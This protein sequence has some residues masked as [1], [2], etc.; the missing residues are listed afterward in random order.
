MSYYFKILIIQT[1]IKCFENIVPEADLMF[2]YNEVHKME[3]GLT[4]KVFV[5]HEAF[6]G[7]EEEKG[8]Q[9]EAVIDKNVTRLQASG[10]IPE[11]CLFDRRHS[12]LRI[13]EVRQSFPAQY[14]VGC[15][16]GYEKT[17]MDVN[18]EYKPFKQ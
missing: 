1:F 2:Y 15:N 5:K 6:V 18:G 13:I 4:G 17:M 14:V 10:E 7:D 9:L 12:G 8:F 3:E 16:C 11:A